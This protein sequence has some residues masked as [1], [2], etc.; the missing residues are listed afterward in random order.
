MG[1]EKNNESSSE[2][3]LSSQDLIQNTKDLSECPEFIELYRQIEKA[4][5]NYI[6]V[7]GRAI[8]NAEL[9][10]ISEGS[11]RDIV[12]LKDKYGR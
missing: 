9:I 7:L 2:P 1:P 10:E 5:N 12:R 8:K 3:E 6:D 11:D 4:Y